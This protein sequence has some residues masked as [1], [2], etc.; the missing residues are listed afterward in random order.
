MYDDKGLKRQ[1]TPKEIGDKL[2][3]TQERVR[4]LIDSSIAKMREMHTRTSNSYAV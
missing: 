2:G 4:Q 3:L 1:F